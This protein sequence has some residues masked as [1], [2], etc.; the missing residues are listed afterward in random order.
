[1]IITKTFEEIINTPLTE[2]Q[3]AELKALKDRPVTPDED[4]P[5]LT[6]EQIAEFKK[7]A[8]ERRA[9]KNIR[10]V[11]VSL[12]PQAFAKAESFGDRYSDILSRIL[13]NALNDPNIINDPEILK[14]N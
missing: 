14:V 13:E 9:R 4:C 5:E 7:A 8:E 11:T 2:E 10:T 12:S 3:K 6:P 1:M